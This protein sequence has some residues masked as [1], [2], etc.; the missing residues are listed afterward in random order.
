MQ[1]MC[2]YVDF[3][4]IFFVYSHGIWLYLFSGILFLFHEIIC[5]TEEKYFRNEIFEINN[6]QSTIVFLFVWF[7]MSVNFR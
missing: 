7:E 5:L 4:S 2:E 6:I 3:V 1:H